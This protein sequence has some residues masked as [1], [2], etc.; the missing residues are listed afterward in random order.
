MFLIKKILNIKK[1][2]YKIILI[3]SFIISWTSIGTH[4][5]NLLIF[6]S[7]EG[8]S[9]VE[10]INFIRITANLFFFPILC[11]MLFT[12]ISQYKKANINPYLAFFIPLLCLLSQIPGLF[13]TPNSLW[14]ILYVLSA[15]NILITLNLIILNF[16]N[17]EL[18]F[19]IFVTFYLLLIVFFISFTQD[20]TRYFNSG[21]LFYGRVNYIIGDTHIR[22]SGTS[23]IALILL[24]IYS[25]FFMKFF[26]YKILQIIPLI[27]FCSSIFLY[28]SRANIGLTII[29]I[30]LNYLILEKYT[31]ITFFKNLL[32][33]FVLPSLL[34]FLIL[35]LQIKKLDKFIDIDYSNIEGYQKKIDPEYNMS[36]ETDV[37]ILK[38]KL[39]FFKPNQ[40]N[41]SSG[42][43]E[44]WKTIINNFD[45]NNNLFFGYG[46]QG[47]RYLI[48][49]TASNALMYV[50]VSSGFV[51]LVF[52]TIITLKS[53]IQIMK[54]IFFNKQKISI[55]YFSFIIMIVILIRSLIETS[56][57]L[58]SVDF[59]LFYT[60]FILMQRNEN[61]K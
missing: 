17:D 40:I 35:S 30:I 58:F 23:R 31:L 50:F 27:F 24:I 59:I 43:I 61:L 9:L 4:Y 1:I 6:T 57:S 36:I 49:Q 28:Q 8:V 56:Y 55:Y 21:H 44:D 34:T 51:G 42:R 7:N 5:T 25:I 60:A 13:Y 37:M 48:N 39:R 2:Y 29:F 46:A 41:S 53:S 12:N 15:I 19:I 26:R 47:D 54:Y 10:V 22:S 52:F 32:I 16:E 20:I 33:Y 18:H 45:Y 38:N 14:N 3:L 11:I